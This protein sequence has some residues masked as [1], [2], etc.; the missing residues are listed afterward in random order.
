LT[1]ACIVQY[2]PDC[3]FPIQNCP[4]GVF[5]TVGTQPRC[6]V[7][8]GDMVLDLS[9]LHV[10]GVF[11]DFDSSCFCE[12]ALNRF[13][14]MGKQVW[15][16][17]RDRIQQVLSTNDPTLRDNAELRNA[18]LIPMSSVTM[19]L[20]SKI[21]DYT[22]FYSSRE[23]AT[24]VG[25]MFRGRDNA[26][27]PNWLH[28]PVGY[29]GRASSVVVSGQPIIRPR[30]QLQIH[31]EDATQGSVYDEC[32]TLDFELEM[33][34]FVGPGSPLG[35]PIDIN[36]AADHIFG[37]V[38]VNDWSARD[39]QK[40]EYVPLGPFGAKNFGTTIS[41]WVVPIDAL[42]QFKCPTSAGVQ[43]PTPLPY[44]QEPDYSSY[45]VNLEVALQS[46]A[47]VEPHVICRSNL[48]NLYWTIRQQLVHHTI[49]GCNMQPGDL[50]ATGTISGQDETSYVSMLELSWKGTKEI[51][52]PDG[53]IR[54][55]LRDGDTV[56]MRGFCQGD[57]YRIGFGTCSGKV[58]PA[59]IRDRVPASQLPLTVFPQTSL[60]PHSFKLYSYWRSSCS[61]RVRLAMAYKGLNYEYIPVHLIKDG[62]Q[63][64]HDLYKVKNPLRQVPTLEYE[65]NGQT[66]SI[67]QSVAILEWLEEKF[68]YPA[69]LPRDS[70]LRLKVRQIVECINS[71]IQPLQNLSL[72]QTLNN[73]GIDGKVFARDSIFQGLTALESIVSKSSGTFC[74]G[75]NIS[76]ADL[77]LLPQLYNA[78]RYEIDVN[79][80]P[81][82]LRIESNC[83]QFPV[84]LSAHPDRVPDANT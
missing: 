55:F 54:K 7:A 70:N 25:I 61:W 79:L 21:G 26:L 34:F 18:A 24:N 45:D 14:A 50:L 64:H 1:M 63:Q 3:E 6:G 15:K 83:Q 17:V 42:A 9:V 5:S 84:L 38:L 41:P 2:T 76:F 58:L 48:R 80:F 68:P 78:R 71:G 67:T 28:L 66:F 73:Q 8:I 37:M 49:T 31:P 10:A 32:K 19:H 4:Y 39:I 13:M 27:Q 51:P 59:N 44:L 35:Y 23:H 74:V 57:G 77:A 62:G 82:L 30:G 52:L 46:E 81:T 43:D 36:N 11:S 16:I 69:L 29:H 12:P 40:F 60:L 75:D 72:I 53:S 20:P 22:D 33:G 56:I 47:M 65:E